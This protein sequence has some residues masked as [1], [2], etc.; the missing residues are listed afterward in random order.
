MFI[1][2]KYSLKFKGVLFLG[3]LLSFSSF[4]LSKNDTLVILQNIE[5]A[6]EQ[7]SKNPGVGL[8][9]AVKA[10]NL[11][12]KCENQK[13]IG[14]ANNTLGSAYYFLGNID[15]SEVYHSKAL[16]IQLTINDPEGLGRSY[17]NLG[18]I[19]SEK[20]LNDKAITYF[21]KAEKTFI[22]IKYLLGLSKTYNSLGILFYNI[23]DYDNSVKYYTAGLKLAREL[24]D[25][26]LCYSIG[27]N[28]ANTL[29]S[30]NKNKEALFLYMSSYNIA[31]KQENYSDLVTI[32][33]SI[34]Q[35]YLSLNNL[36]SARKYDYEAL[37]I[38]RTYQ[39]SDYFKV[40]AF[41]NHGIILKN[42]GKYEEAILYLDSALFYAK[43]NSALE[44][45]IALHIELSQL[46][47]KEK[48]YQRA[49]ENLTMA[50]ELK[51]SLYAKNLEEKLAE[52]N[53]V[54]NTDKKD[55]EIALLNNQKINQRKINSLLVVIVVISV[56][57]LII[58]IYSYLRKRKANDLIAKQ[59]EEVEKKN[60]I[61]E[62]K[63]KEIIDSISYAQRIQKAHLPT[64]NY[65]NRYLRD[66]N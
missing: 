17:A 58:A 41:G 2:E 16:E 34:C 31:K 40:S 6:R 48:K 8:K 38:I 62:D 25:E 56:I 30:Q 42:V 1:F 5:Y 9:F 28:F 45:Q 13:F 39:L 66:W 52:I 12:L 51:D 53:A 21:L 65:M 60:L 10:L 3:A 15:S 44:K 43:R 36:L 59:K 19:Y 4:L 61:I 18:S 23:K 63:Q 24:K 50:T 37:S 46:F 26:T 32:C 29:S 33:N 49:V 35:Q 11:A 55:Q 20:G 57:A 22:R 27:T 14:K 7:F 64:D 47:L 54:H